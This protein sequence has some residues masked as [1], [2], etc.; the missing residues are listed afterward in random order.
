LGIPWLL[1]VRSAQTTTAPVL[2]LTPHV[3]IPLPEPLAQATQLTLT[4]TRVVTA[5]FPAGAQAQEQDFA[6]FYNG[7]QVTTLRVYT[8]IT[9]TITGTVGVALP[10]LFMVYPT[11]VDLWQQVSTAY[12][13]QGFALIA[14]SPIGERAVNIDA[15]AQDARVALTLALQGK[16]NMQV[17]GGQVIALGGSF[18]SAILHRLLRDTGEHVAGWVTVGGI[19]NAFSGTADFYAGRLV[20]PPQYEYLI[21]AL[22]Q[23]HIY[24]LPFLRFSPVYS[25]AQLPPTLIIHTDVDHVIPI[26]QAYQLEAALRAAQVPV[27][28]YYY[29]D[30]SHYLQIDEA[31]TDAG[32][33]MFFRVADFARRVLAH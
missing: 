15:H 7:A 4:A 10:T 3:A 5:S 16:L 22:G 8:P 12:A 13:S 27:E 24:P 30:V 32:R 31:M 9:G 25:A 29:R 21:P 14:I 23:P 2:E 11:Q 17:R 28:V 33:S 19:S 1:S 6:F 26:D 18:S 20:L